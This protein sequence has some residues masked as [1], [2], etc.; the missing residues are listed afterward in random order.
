MV[1]TKINWQNGRVQ[2]MTLQADTR[3]SFTGGLHTQNNGYLLLIRQPASG[4]HEIHWPKDI[5]WLNGPPELT[6][7]PEKIDI[8][9]LSFRNGRY[10]AKYSLDY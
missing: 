2:T 8:I 1:D 7:M 4:V 3:L 10:F 5:R 9:S 6:K